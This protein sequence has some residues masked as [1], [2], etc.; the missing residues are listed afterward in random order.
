VRTLA[1]ETVE[2]T[3]AETNIAATMRV[4][5]LG[6]AWS[7]DIDLHV[8]AQPSSRALEDA[9]WISLDA[10]LRRIGSRGRGRWAVVK[11]NEV[12]ACADFTSEGVPDPV[13]AIVRRCTER[14]EVRLRE[15]LELRELVRRGNRLPDGPVIRAA[16]AAEAALGGFLLGGTAGLDPSEPPVR[17]A[18]P[19][20]RQRAR[21]L[22][23]LGRRRVVVAIAG[24]D[25][26][27][28]STLSSALVDSLRRCGVPAEIVWT[29]PG[30]RIGWLH[31]LAAIAKRILGQ[32]KEPG[33]REMARGSGDALAS[34]RGAIGWIWS[35]LVTVAF[36]VDVWKR[37]LRARGVLLY[38]RHLLDALATIRLAYAGV[39]VRA[40]ERL[41]R[42]VLPRATVT[43]YLDVPA[44]VAVARKPDD[45]I[46]TYAVERQLASYDELLREMERDGAPLVNLDATSPP[47]ELVIAAFR[48]VSLP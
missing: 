42:A 48:A 39:D 29:R 23:R 7:R 18:A 35:A 5:P 4:S 15:V 8:E 45:V 10:L 2:A 20:L 11:D 26:A 30:L 21:R 12:L 41:L 28:K 24:V 44:E 40:H 31:Q 33:V 16:A 1:A 14:G 9:G 32:K 46:G 17:L 34:R 38:D 47:E 22:G 6:A 19:T 37:H 43:I 36:V 13:A 27:G 25:G 3:L